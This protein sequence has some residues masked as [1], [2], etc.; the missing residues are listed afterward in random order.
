MTVELGLCEICGHPLEI[1]TKPVRRLSWTHHWWTGFSSLFG[2]P[3]R[4]CTSC[5]AIYSEEG[6]LLAAGAVQTE[7]EQKLDLYRRDMSY[8]RD[9]FGGVIVAAELAALWLV[10]GAESANPLGA[11]LAASIGVVSF[12]PFGYFALKARRARKDL[13]LLKTARVKGQLHPHAGD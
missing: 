13:K 11:L 9:S 4:V 5:G 12:A 1:L 10:A 6:G 8:L 2:R 7:A 3:L